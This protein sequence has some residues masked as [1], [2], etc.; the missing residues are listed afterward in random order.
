MS[1]KSVLNCPNCSSGQDALKLIIYSYAPNNAW[2]C[3]VCNANLKF[4]QIRAFL[5]IVIWIIGTIISIVTFDGFSQEW[6]WVFPYF[7]L[8][9][10]SRF[11]KIMLEG[12]FHNDIEQKTFHEK[13]PTQLHLSTLILLNAIAGI[14]I[15]IDVFAYKLFQE[16]M[17]DKAL[18]TL[19]F[20]NAIL[21]LPLF[22]RLSKA[23][24]TRVQNKNTN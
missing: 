21:V 17:Q 19:L 2:N 23:L 10:V 18:G 5:L 9:L 3:E 24:M 6:I 8:I 13:Q 11:Q 20:F 12:D 15:G 4:S 14:I 1:E 16:Q 7:T 22:F